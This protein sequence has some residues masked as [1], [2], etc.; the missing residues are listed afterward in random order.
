MTMAS[1]SASLEH[2]TR[3]TTY[4]VGYIALNQKLSCIVCAKSC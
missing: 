4:H 2:K 1:L 3:G